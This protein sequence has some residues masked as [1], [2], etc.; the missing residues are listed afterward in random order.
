MSDGGPVD[1]WNEKRRQT[2]PRGGRERWKQGLRRILLLLVCVESP[3]WL[4]CEV[5]GRLGVQV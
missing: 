4:D 5:L 2:R 3:V 1:Q